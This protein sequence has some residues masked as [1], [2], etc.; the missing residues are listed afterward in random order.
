MTGLTGLTGPNGPIATDGL[1]ETCQ[2]Q[3]S[4]VT[5]Q[6][7]HYRQELV[8]LI[9][10]C[11]LTVVVTDAIVSK[12]GQ[13]GASHPDCHNLIQVAIQQLERQLYRDEVFAQCPNMNWAAQCA[14]RQPRAARP[15]TQHLSWG[16][17][18]RMSYLSDKRSSSNDEDLSLIDSQCDDDEMPSFVPIDVPPRW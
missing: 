13:A 9:R 16:C 1:T 8:K 3:L 18:T 4:D 6:N 17:P 5:G 10:R 11:Q 12:Y 7:L 14:G 15:S 2:L